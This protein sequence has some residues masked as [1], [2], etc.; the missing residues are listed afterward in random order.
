[1]HGVSAV[2]KGVGQTCQVFLNLFE[3]ACDQYHCQRYD[4]RITSR[5][6]NVGNLLDASYCQMALRTYSP[7]NRKNRLALRENSAMVKLA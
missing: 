6:R 3:R 4:S 7:V 1:M 2:S 5:W